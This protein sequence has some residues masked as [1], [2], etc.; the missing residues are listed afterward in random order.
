MSAPDKFLPCLLQEEITP[1]KT[2]WRRFSIQADLGWFEGH[3]PT[4]AIL[5]GV[6]QLHWAVEAAKRLRESQLL[7]LSMRQ[8][9]FKA[10]IRPGV[11]LDLKVE[12]V[13][14][15]EVRF[16][17]ESEQGV[18]SSGSFLYASA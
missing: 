16:S 7:P 3:F 11:V 17:Y 2:L 18:H 6:V 5:A 8:L 1:F 13:S 9:K 12:Q 10:P 4:E 15:D 14:A